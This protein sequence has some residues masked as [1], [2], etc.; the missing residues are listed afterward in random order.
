M[1]LLSRLKDRG[2]ECRSIEHAEQTGSVMKFRV[3]NTGSR[4]LVC[5]TRSSGFDIGKSVKAGALIMTE[6][7]A[8]HKARPERSKVKA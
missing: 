7:P 8:M 2:F 5:Y 4:K 3:D 1:I 6:V